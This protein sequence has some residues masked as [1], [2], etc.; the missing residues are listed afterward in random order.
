MNLD[1]IALACVG[2]A[3]SSR[4]AAWVLIRLMLW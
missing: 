3:R 4:N 1:E 2:L